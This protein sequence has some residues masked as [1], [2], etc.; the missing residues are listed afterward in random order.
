MPELTRQ[1]VAALADEFGIPVIEDH[2]LSELSIEGSPPG[3]IARY[4][5][6]GT[7]LT[8]GSMSKLFWGGL[9]VGWVRGP[10]AAIAQLACVK[11][12]ADLGSASVTHAIAAQLLTALD[13]AK[14][15]RREQHLRRR[16]HL[17]SLLRERLPEWQFTQPQGGFFL[18][19]RLPAGD[20]RYFAQCSARHGVAVT[21][22]S[23][24]AADESLAEYLRIPFVLDE[25]S[26]ALGV[27]RLTAAW[28]EFRGIANARLTRSAP[29]V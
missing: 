4:S 17:V 9:R 16:D 22:G 15:I 5:R 20:G 2:T 10:V 11:T 23:V 25:A 14:A 19:V 24:F 7:V 3:L 8:V 1:C 13:R 18:W 21:P 27:D 12:A 6:E 26:I 28:S 29:I